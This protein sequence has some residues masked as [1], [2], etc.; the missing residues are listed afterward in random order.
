[1]R[2][3]PGEVWFLPPEAEEGGDPKDRR[4]VLL[5]TC[6]AVE[7]IG[8]FAYA[9]TQPTEAQNGATYLLVDPAVSRYAPTGFARP[10]YVYLSR[11]V[12]AR[13]ENLLRMTGRLV[14]EMPHLRLLLREALGVGT[15]T[16]SGDRADGSNWRGRVV[17]LSSSRRESI[18]YAYAIV[19]TEPR[20]SQRQRYQIVVPVDDL[21]EFEPVLGD[22]K[23]TQGDWFSAIAP[24]LTG[25]LIA[26]P[27]VQ[28]IFHP[29]EIEDWT[30][31]VVDDTTMTEVEAALIGMFDL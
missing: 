31:A 5:T 25:V 12:P 29:R 19:V 24:G 1:M 9:S 7:D 26:V 22:V 27:D 14:D 21:R 18:G 15:G 17:Q 4:H 30:G 16:T 3:Y 2:R 10:S 8:V 13:S 6:D 20:Y 11:L 28:S 23:V